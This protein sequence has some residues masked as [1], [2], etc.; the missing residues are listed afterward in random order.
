MVDAPYLYI[1]FIGI[2]G[3]NAVSP[4][5]TEPLDRGLLWELVKIRGATHVSLYDN[6][7]R[8]AQAIGAMHVFFQKRG[9]IN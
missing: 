4:G 2:T 6:I 8:I 7:D 1:P 5:D 3:S 9:D